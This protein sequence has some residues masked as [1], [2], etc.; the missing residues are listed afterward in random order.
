LATKRRRALDDLLAH[1]EVVLVQ[2]ATGRDQIDD[3]SAEPDQRRQLDRS[4]HLD[5]LDLAP[6]LLEVALGDPR[7]LAG[8]PHHPQPPLRLAEAARRPC[9]REHHAAAAVAEVEQ[10]V[11]HASACSSSTSLPVMPTS[12][13]PA[14]T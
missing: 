3:P 6:G 13:A 2:G 7:V 4:L 8:D 14:S 5:H 1:L 11:D 9:D 12:A 10:L